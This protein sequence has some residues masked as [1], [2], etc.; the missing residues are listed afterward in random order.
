MPSVYAE[1]GL[2]ISLTELYND[3]PKVVG[4]SSPDEKPYV[5]DFAFIRRIA[6]ELIFLDIRP[7]LHEK[8]YGEQDD[9][10]D[11]SPGTE[12]GLI[13]SSHVRRIQDS[14]R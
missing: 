3:L 11:I 10:S 9:S 2:L 1:S 4:M 14:H 12:V 8:A 7:C 6:P 5:T 13:K